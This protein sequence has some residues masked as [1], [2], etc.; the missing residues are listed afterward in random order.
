MENLS[1]RIKVFEPEEDVNCRSA[2]MNLEFDPK[3]MPA[4]MVGDIG[5]LNYSPLLQNATL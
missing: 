3:S 1:P 4:G 5:S 2:L